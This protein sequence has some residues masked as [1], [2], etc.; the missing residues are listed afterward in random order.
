MVQINI[1]ANTAK[2]KVGISLCGNRKRKPCC[3]KETVTL[4]YNPRGLKLSIDMRASFEK[5]ASLMNAY[6]AFVFTNDKMHKLL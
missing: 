6:G 1:L 3:R 5:Y 4:Q 2:K